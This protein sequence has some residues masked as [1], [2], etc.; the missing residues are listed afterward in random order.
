MRQRLCQRTEEALYGGS[1]F[2]C[3]FWTLFWGLLSQAFVSHEPA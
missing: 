3:E 2:C 1:G